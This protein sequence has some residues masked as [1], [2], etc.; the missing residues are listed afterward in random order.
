MVQRVN[1]EIDKREKIIDIFM[2]V[3]IIPFDIITFQAFTI[4]VRYRSFTINKPSMFSIASQLRLEIAVRLH[5]SN[6]ST[7]SRGNTLC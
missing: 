3:Y 1:L 7:A 2:L 6:V 5:K 4:N